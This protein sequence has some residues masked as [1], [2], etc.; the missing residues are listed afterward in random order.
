MRLS[1]GSV[2]HPLHHFATRP[3][4]STLSPSF[5]LSMKH[6]CISLGRCYNFKFCATQ[7]RW[8]GYDWVKLLKYRN[9]MLHKYHHFHHCRH[10]LSIITQQHQMNQHYPH[11]LTKCSKHIHQW[12]Y[13]SNYKFEGYTAQDNEVKWRISAAPIA[14]FATRPD[15]S[16]LSPSFILSIKHVCI[17]LGRCYIFKFVCYTSKMIR[18]WLGQATQTSKQNAAQILS[19]YLKYR[20]TH[21]WRHHLTIIQYRHIMYQ[22]QPTRA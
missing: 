4:S 15:N 8:L 19:F 13:C 12:G 9:K 16:T 22:K 7:A 1:E 3:D 10:H 5:I 2:Q 14:S 11:Y 6:V 18:I 20:M 17:S 21:H